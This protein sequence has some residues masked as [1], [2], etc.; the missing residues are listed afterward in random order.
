MCLVFMSMRPGN[1]KVCG[2]VK[3]NILLPI[4]GGQAICIN[5][6]ICVLGDDC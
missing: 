2:G 6:Y 5:Y 4:L 3:L 1:I